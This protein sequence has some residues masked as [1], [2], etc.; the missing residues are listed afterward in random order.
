MSWGGKHLSRLTGAATIAVLILTGWQFGHPAPPPATAYLPAAAPVAGS[1]RAHFFG[2]TTLL[3]SDGANAVMIDAL[4]TRP[5]LRQALFGKIASDPA[6]IALLLGKA[7]ARPVDLLFISHSHYDHALDAGEIARQ[8]GATIVGSP[9]TR[10]IALGAG[11]PVNRIRVVNGGERIE[12]GAFAVTVF[13]SAHSPGDRVPGTIAAPLHQPASIKDYKE[14]GTLAFLIEH[15]GLRML[16]HAS[17]NYVPGMYHGVRADVVFLSIGGL[18]GQ[19]AEFARNYW[20]EVVKTTG[21]KLV[22]PIHWDDFLRP[23]D[24]PQLPLRRFMDDFPAALGKLTPLAR[25]DRVTIRYM[26]VI[27]PVDIAAAAGAAQN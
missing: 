5:G 17:A 7:Q 23:L 1:L 12:D 14:G 21:A 15:K 18:G 13:R 11:I 26:P 6:A 27:V 4:L 25:R 9:S 3:L 20:N 10:E 2:T 16:V 24:R 8:T 19:S 22:I